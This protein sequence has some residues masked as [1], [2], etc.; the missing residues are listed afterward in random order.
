MKF[1]LCILVT[2]SFALARVCH[3]KVHF[4][5]AKS[6][7][8]WAM[9][10]YRD[11]TCASATDYDYYSHSLAYIKGH[12]SCNNLTVHSVNYV[13]SFVAQ[14]R[15]GPKILAFYKGYGCSGGETEKNEIALANGINGVA[16]Y[17]QKAK[18]F[19][20]SAYVY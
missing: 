15:D 17:N 19:R 3:E 13:G 1:T 5:D 11:G 18:S 8:T 10:V 14:I 6:H 20:I 9:K 7:D 12:S 16:H 2:A 4:K